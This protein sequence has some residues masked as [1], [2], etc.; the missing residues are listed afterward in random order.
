MRP[1]LMAILQVLLATA[2][3]MSCKDRYARAEL[4][5]VRARQ[6]SLA[7]VLLE[8]EVRLSSSA[9]RRPARTTISVDA[10]ASGRMGSDT[11]PL[12]IIEFTDY[13]WPFCARFAPSGP[14]P[15]KRLH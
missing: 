11:A 14:P 13:Q 10:K 4:Q 1:R 7:H 5:R 6:D 15:L 8:M 3:P 9:G 2:A 12:L